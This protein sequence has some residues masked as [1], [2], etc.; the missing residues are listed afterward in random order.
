M[1]LEATMLQENMAVEANNCENGNLLPKTPKLD[2]IYDEEPLGFEKDPSSSSQKMQAQDPLEEIDIGNGLL[3]RPTY[4]SANI[5]KDF[6]EKLVELLKEFKDCFAWDYNEMPGLDRNL[7]EHRLPIR[8]DKK[9]VKQ[10]PRRF[11]PEILSK[12]KE[13]IERLLRSKFIRTARY[14]EWLANIVPVIKKNGSLRICIDF[15]DLNNA[16]PKDE[17]SMPVAEMLIDSA[18]GFEYLSMLDGYSGYNQIFIAEEDVAKTAFRCPGALGTYEWVVMPFGLKNAGATYQRAMNSIFHDF[19]DTFMQVY[20]DDIIV[21]SASQDDHLLCLRKSFER[22]RKYGLKMNPLKCAFCVHAGDFLGFVVHKKGIEINQNKTKAILE[23]N[24]PTNK[25]QL[26]SLLG[27]INFLRRFISNLSGKAQAF[28]PLLRLKKEDVFTWG[29][30]QQEAFEEL[31]KYLSNPPTL[32]PP[33]RNKF[34]KLYISASDTTLGSMLAQEDENGEE[35]AIYYLSRVLNDLSNRLRFYVAIEPWTLYFDGSRHQ[36]GTGIGLEIL[37]SLGAKEVK[38]RGDSELVLK[39][40]TREY[41]CIKEH[42]IRYFVIANAL[43]KRFDSIDIEHVPRIENQEA[44]DLAQI[45][46]GYKMSKETL[47]QLI[48]IKEKLILNEPMQSKLSMP[49]LEGA[50]MP[51]NDINHPNKELEYDEFQIFVIDNLLDGDWRKPIAD[52][53]ENPIG[54]TPR[55]IKYKASNY[56][57]IGNELFKKTLEGVLLKCLSENEAYLAISD[58]HSGACGSHQ[59]GHKM[60]WLLVRQGMYWP[61]MLRNCIDFAKGC[62]E[63]QKHGGIQHVP[64]SELHSIIKPWPFRGWALDLIGEIKPASSKNQRYIIVGIDYFTKWI[65]AVP[66]P[67]VDQ[68]EVI[69]FIQNHIIYRFGI[70][71]TITTDQGS[72]FTGRKMQ[73]FAQQTGFKLLTSTPYYAQANGQVEAA[74]KI[75][76]GLIRKHIAQKPRNWNKTL[77]QVLWACRNSPKESTNSTP[78]RLTYGH[79]AVLPVEIYLQSIRIQR[80][81]DLPVDHYWNMM[82][83]ELVDLDEERLRALDT[84]SRQKERVAKAYNKKVKSK[85]FD[86]GELVWKVILPMDK[87]DRILGKWSPNWEGPFK[88]T[89]IFSNGAYEI[90]ELTSEKRTL[91][92]NGKYLKKY[93][94]T[95]LE[96]KI[97][98]E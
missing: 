5:P 98:T 10:S 94:P 49:K 61:S 22:M 91:N 33:I 14:V 24:P 52:Y 53:L 58:V 83:D 77:N 31:K 48:E 54:S 30:D 7:V 27:K 66:L 15:R 43:L 59:S 28:S 50:E 60:K 74:N 87:K 45:A 65:E 97:S 42:L 6:R 34:M 79:D 32:M 38:I 4:I 81:V 95:L 67:N 8:P 84:L 17:Y 55:N 16:T 11:A 40:L 13:E 62:Q 18:T 76:I 12:I 29:Q 1:A 69:S 63:C 80:Q 9:P 72:V 46:S 88:I 56:V 93:K 51:L 86:V 47:G 89:Q 25:K 37:L 71:E 78:F 21:K 41:K 68:E 35:K 64:A 23:T 44:N 92:I 3:K 26:Q 57:I 96:V 75:I 82:F 2:C 90:E 19:I 70:P 85:A 39:Q 36:H 20:I 73:E